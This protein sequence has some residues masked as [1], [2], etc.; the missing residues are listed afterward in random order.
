MKV[1]SHLS[2]YRVRIHHSPGLRFLG[3]VYRC[4]RRR[5]KLGPQH[6]YYRAPD[7]HKFWG[8]ST[9]SLWIA[10]T[11]RERCHTSPN[12]IKRRVSIIVE[13]CNF[14]AYWPGHSGWSAN[15]AKRSEHIHIS[16]G[17]FSTLWIGALP[18]DA[19]RGRGLLDTDESWVI[20]SLGSS[21]LCAFIT[22]QSSFGNGGDEEGIGRDSGGEDVVVNVFWC[23]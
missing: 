22:D 3:D 2:T 7:R 14:N 21:W 11:W 12:T 13:Y 20:P 6:S 1:L 5:R 18:P 9:S 4:R 8:V 23:R 19:G 17:K 15:L 16:S 10:R